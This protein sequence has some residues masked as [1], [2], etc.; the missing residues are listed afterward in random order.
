MNTETFSQVNWIA[1]FCGALA[2]FMLGALWYSKLLF[3]KKWLEY[4]KIDPDHADAKKGMAALMIGSFITMF[5]VSTIIAIVRLK[6][7]ISGTSSGL[8]LGLA[9]G[10]LG[11]FSI[12]INYLYEKRPAGL[13][14]ING[15]YVIAG[16]ILA[17][18]IICNW[19]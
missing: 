4:L 13:F 8:K 18:L 3:V 2:Y 14:L 17:A 1:V 5:L 12:F 19:T 7:D 11:S 9:T 15:G 16:N 10:L 6:L